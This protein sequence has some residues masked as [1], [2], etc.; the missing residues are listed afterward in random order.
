MKKYLKWIL[1]AIVAVFALIQLVNPSRMN[2][3][4]KR[5]F[6][7]ASQ[8]AGVGRRFDSRGVLRL[9]F[10]RNDLAVVFA[11]RAGVMAHCLRR[12]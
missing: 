10:G 12:E 11:H 3:P 1:P 9:P 4:V 5:D 7:A 6:I 8:A 2:P